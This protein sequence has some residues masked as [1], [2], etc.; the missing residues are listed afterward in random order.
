[1][2]QRRVALITGA[3][4][5]LGASFARQLARAGHDLVL[6][7]RQEDRLRSLAEDLERSHGIRAHA[8]VQDL[9]DRAAVDQIHART[10]ALGLDV[11]VLVNNAGFHLD[12]LFRELPWPTLRDNLRLLLDVVVEMT[13]KFLPSM[14]ERGWGR[15]INVSSVSGFMP[16]GIRLATYTASKCFLIPFSEG[17]N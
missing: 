13:H 3:A 15:V 16:G 2:S 7:D 8:L 4:A 5:G 12:K 10:R 9:Y 11:D 17:L 14:V 6:V 1:M